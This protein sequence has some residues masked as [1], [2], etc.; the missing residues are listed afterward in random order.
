MNDNS[1]EIIV[2]G[3]VLIK[4]IDSKNKIT[5]SQKDT[6]KKIWDKECKIKNYKIFND[7]VLS[8][9]DIH[10]ENHNVIVSAKFT[11]YKNVLASRKKPQ[12]G[13]SIKQI[14]V[15]GI[16]IIECKKQF[17]LFATRSTD[18]TEYPRYLELVPSGNI[19]KS[20]LRDNGTID[21]ISKIKEEFKEET[22]LSPKYIKQVKSFC[23]VYD[24]KNQVFDVVCLIALD[25]D[26]KRIIESFKKVSEY[27]N[28]QLVPLEDLYNFVR[29]NKQKIVP[30]S[31]AI[32]ECFI[33]LQK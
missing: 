32:L 17:I 15:S 10:K 14:G 16:I 20:V 3:N 23:F 2:R 11:E 27:K 25:I 18:T 31:L 5:T 13:L 9:V 28:P 29:Q 21:Y 4:C 6:I 26:P 8:F 12:L 24:K 22:G 30:T 7:E 1:F 19:D 33:N